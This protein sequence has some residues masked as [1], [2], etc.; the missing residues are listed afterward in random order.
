MVAFLRVKGR[1]QE[2]NEKK[3]CHTI[4]GVQGDIHEKHLCTFSRDYLINRTPID[5]KE[6]KKLKYGEKK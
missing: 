2:Q 6:C 3:M 1:F 5:E 4:V